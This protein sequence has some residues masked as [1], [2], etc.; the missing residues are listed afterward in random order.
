MRKRVSTLALAML[1]TLGGLMNTTASATENTAQA[2]AAAA[3]TAEIAA[4]AAEIA[5]QTD[6]DAAQTAEPTAQ[7]DTDAAQADAQASGAEELYWP[8]GV[9][10]DAPCAIVMEASTG[11]V[12]YEKNADEVHYPASITKI[13]T[14]LLALENCDLDEVVTFSADAVYKNE[15]DTSHIARDLEE[16][17][18]MEE[19][20]YAV[21]LESANEC[22][23]AVAEHVGGGD[24]QKFIDMMNERA[25]ELGCTNTHFNNCNGLPDENHTTSTR[26][27]ALIAQAAYENAAFRQIMS[28]KQ[29]TIPPTNK[30]STETYLYNH[31]QM[32]SA[33]KTTANLYE[34]ALGGKTGYTSVALNTLVTYAQ[35]D[36]M[37]LICVVMNCTGGHYASTRTLFDYCFDNFKLCS[38]AENETRYAAEDA[39]EDS[40]F[41]TGEDFAAI[42]S[43]ARIVLPVTADF[44]DTRTELQ[45]DLVSDNVLGTLV[46]TYG[47][48]T[49]GTADVVTTGAQITPYPFGKTL[50][51]TAGEKK[52][53]DSDQAAS[54]DET[55]AAKDSGSGQQ[56]AVSQESVIRIALIAGA[57]VLALIIVW[58]LYNNLTRIRR[59]RHRSDERY[60]EIKRSSKWNRRGGS[61]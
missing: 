54:A 15:G 49:V 12:L 38:V 45:Y 44:S 41:V 3:Q 56:A 11:T 46:Y 40:L 60:K 24:Y 42:D 33:N 20:L 36:G 59:K 14:T 48:R 43:D 25:A 27:M 51:K 47:D 7:T 19:C 31:H 23:Y 30:H 55:D 13:M 22:A 37:T 29:Y 39:A 8:S 58:F 50:G 35:K 17:M 4:S 52:A 32:I 10:V 53:A 9:E 6:T 2:E 16:Q 57:A 21:M 1:L 34:Y 18:T 61:R 5:A 26:D 28:T